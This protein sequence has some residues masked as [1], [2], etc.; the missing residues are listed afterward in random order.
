M[1]LFLC[2]C[3]IKVS[4]FIASK[5]F[6]SN[7]K[8]P[9]AVIIA[10][11]AGSAWRLDKMRDFEFK[12]KCLGIE[13]DPAILEILNQIKQQTS[14]LENLWEE[15]KNPEYTLKWWQDG[16]YDSERA[17]TANDK[18]LL[19]FKEK[20]YGEAF[21]AFTEAIR[22]CPTASV[23]HSNRSAAALKI[24]KA[25]IAAQD[26]ENALELNPQNLK[27]LLRAGYAY[28]RL[29]NAGKA[30][31]YFKRAVEVDS[32]CSAAMWGLLDAANLQ[33]RLN[34]QEAA[35]QA[36]SDA[37]TRPPLSRKAESVKLATLQLIS[38]DQVLSTSPTSQSALL[39]KIEALITCTRYVDAL[40]TCE[41]LRNGLERIYLEAEAC[42]RN[43]DVAKALEKVH[44]AAI[45]GSASLPEKFGDLETFLKWINNL[46]KRIK[47]STEEGLYQD[48]IDIATELLIFLDPGACCGL[49]RRVLCHRANAFASRRLFKE[50]REDLDTAL[51]MQQSDAEALRL[52]ADLNKQTGSYL[53]YFL[54]VQRLKKVA[55]HAPGLG[56]LL[57]DAAR[58]CSFSSQ[59][60]GAN[61]GE[62]KYRSTRGGPLSAYSTLGVK[63]LAEHAEIRKAYLKLAAEWHPDKWAATGSEEERHA[64]EER[65]KKVQ[66]AYEEL[67]I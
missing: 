21:A 5:P 25:D 57:Q 3:Q 60:N 35:D 54:D 41:L 37:G 26:A 58:L 20:E 44:Q 50:A 66:A 7:C 40:I 67:T 62:N 22:L 38:A 56:E 16:E 63:P 1:D 42:W 13:N 24:N 49:Y 32:T 43:G 52:R 39:S 18:G 46:L 64:A 31:S 11:E 12:A 27:A 23:Y 53:E 59:S 17:D 2:L 51:E 45:T 28:I 55:P 6:L 9:N 47:S 61:A 14:E 19:F 34:Q 36:V 15:Q 8:N 33:R 29:R 65:F 48:V 4:I 10:G 30:E